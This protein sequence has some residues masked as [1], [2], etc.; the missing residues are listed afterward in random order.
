MMRKIVVLILCVFMIITGCNSRI[1][2][3]YIHFNPAKIKVGDEIAGLILKSI[4]YDKETKTVNAY[5]EGEVEISGYYM[6]SGY[7][8]PDITS[9]LPKASYEELH[10][11][12]FKLVDMPEYDKEHRMGTI[13]IKDYEIHKGDTKLMN[14]A[15]FV[16]KVD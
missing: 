5:F 8:A 15:I 12:S 9:H 3:H 6:D 13:V 11:N 7:F 16:K 4:D 14:Q 1:D 2:S 10:E